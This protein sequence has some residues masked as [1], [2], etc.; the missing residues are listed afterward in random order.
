MPRADTAS[1]VVALKEIVPDYNPSSHLL[2]RILQIP[3]RT[4]TVPYLA[5]A[6]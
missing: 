4:G 1:L 6:S 2:K 5:A 3:A